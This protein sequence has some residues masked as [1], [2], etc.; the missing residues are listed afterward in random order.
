[1]RVS[2]VFVSYK[3]EDGERVSRLIEW[4]K[5]NNVPVWWD[6]DIG[7]NERWE[8]AIEANLN[9]AAAVIVVWSPASLTSD[10]VI[11]EARVAYHQDK[12]LQISMDGALPP[13]FFRNMQALT[14]NDWSLSPSDPQLAHLLIAVR[15]MLSGKKAQRFESVAQFEAAPRSSENSTL[16]QAQLQIARESWDK[17]ELSITLERA[18]QF[19]EDHLAPIFRSLM[20]RVDDRIAHLEREDEAKREAQRI[21]DEEQRVRAEAQRRAEENVAAELAE[22]A[23]RDGAARLAAAAKA[24]AEEANWQKIVSAAQGLATEID[25]ALG[26]NDAAKE[27]FL[28]IDD[29]A[30]QK[31]ARIRYKLAPNRWWSAFRICVVIAIFLSLAAISFSDTSL[32]VRGLGLPDWLQM[33]WLHL[34]LLA[35]GLGLAA[36][37][38]VS[39]VSIPTPRLSAMSEQNEKT[40]KSYHDTSSSLASF[41]ATY[42]GFKRKLFGLKARRREYLYWDDDKEGEDRSAQLLA[43]LFPDEFK[44][45]LEDSGS[46]RRFSTRDA[47]ASERTVE[48]PLTVR[49]A[50]EER[51]NSQRHGLD[52]LDDILLGTRRALPYELITVDEEP[53]SYLSS[54]MQLLRDGHTIYLSHFRDWGRDALFCLASTILVS[55][56]VFWILP[57]VAFAVGAAF[58]TARA[59]LLWVGG[60]FGFMGTLGDFFGNWV[61]GPVLF[62]LHA[63]TAMNLGPFDDGMIMTLGFALIVAVAAVGGLA[64]ED[65]RLEGAVAALVIYLAFASIV[66]VFYIGLQLT[67]LKAID[68]LFRDVTIQATASPTTVP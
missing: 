10:P 48:I 33:K 25:T 18:R 61:I 60:L 67:P 50:I 32:W 26:N 68:S 43:K 34:L 28:A 36:S 1:M 63:L 12:L 35:A 62:A 54:E 13:F 47:E 42:I 49:S 31:L 27:A 14:I 4:L 65:N 3:R 51:L 11:T 15:A 21:A 20:Y 5:N 38:I 55:Q 39:I 66:W 17:I 16:E 29:L 40:A 53:D 56:L 52:A 30:E 24:A 58:A 45:P 59:G 46:R 8:Q 23:K 57:L 22:K 7:L 64:F 9:S 44:V 6:K 41:L 37:I 19:R 2:H